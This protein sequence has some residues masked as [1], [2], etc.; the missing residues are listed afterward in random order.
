MAPKNTAVF[1]EVIFWKLYSQRNWVQRTTN[2]IMEYI[3][4]NEITSTQ[5]WNAI[6]KFV[7]LQNIENLKE[8][9]NLLGI[10]TNVLAT[11]LT[12]PALAS[13]ETIPMIDTKL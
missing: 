2:R 7:K 13:P 8:I 11:P 6:Q 1:F 12:L 5:L 4:K 3:R 10:S 9:R